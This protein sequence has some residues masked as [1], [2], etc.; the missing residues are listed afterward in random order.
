MQEKDIRE[1]LNQ[2]L[3]QMA[4]DMLNKIL[5]TPIEPVENEKELF[6]KDR[7]LFKER[8]D[9]KPYFKVPAIA[10]LAAC[11]VALIVILYPMLG[12]NH[13]AGKMAFS[14]VIDVN[15]SICIDV[16]ED[17]SVKRVKAKNK[18]AVN[19]VNYI[20]SELSE[21]DDYKIVMELVVK[22]LKKEGYL[23][24][25]KNAML[26]SAISA[27]KNDDVTEAL[28]EVKRRT[29][30][31]LEVRNISCKTIYQKVQ[32]TDK[33]KKVADKNNVSVGKAALCIELAKEEKVSVNKMCKKDIEHLVKKIEKYNY[34]IEGSIIVVDDDSIEIVTEETSTSVETIA[35]ETESIETTTADTESESVSETIEA[36]SESATGVQ[37]TVEE[38]RTV[39]VN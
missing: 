32:V 19:I 2:E 29:N 5:N 1:K 23:N 26:V 15:P 33:V 11:F 9:W 7:P 4:P 34:P 30:E 21:N 17:G 27:D 35:I 12:I 10:A 38:N 39:Y 31:Q 36:P 8:K 37:E 28:K 6:G 14:I 13:T 3:E 16:N 20:N 18:D 22:N 24:K 25:K